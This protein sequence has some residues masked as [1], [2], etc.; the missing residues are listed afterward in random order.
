MPKFTGTRLFSSEGSPPQLGFRTA[1]ALAAMFLFFLL[2]SLQFES[3]AARDAVYAAHPSAA[4]SSS[5]GRAMLSSAARPEADGVSAP[6]LR[7]LSLA[8]AA[9]DDDGTFSAQEDG[10]LQQS[11]AEASDLPVH[12]GA[13]QV[14][15]SILLILISMAL[16][17]QL[18]LGLGARLGT[19]A[20]RCV[21]QLL[22]LGLI[23]GPIFKTNLLPVVILWCMF[24]IGVSALEVT[25]RPT[26]GFR[27]F[28]LH[29][30]MSLAAP[31]FIILCYALLAVLGPRNAMEARYIIP[32]LGM[33]SGVS[34]SYLGHVESGS[35]RGPISGEPSL[36]DLSKDSFP[37]SST[38]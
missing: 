24:M 21:V 19:A 8:A 32:M 34:A 12:L 36:A 20:L 14:F 4:M 30:V 38:K 6:N 7:R 3:A 17:L 23:L 26:H 10:R 27:G 18:H 29:T 31:C 11:A 22:L 5:I 35:G 9:N 13:L 25:S 28:Y 2:G 1:A 15:L 16:Q 33:V 37:S